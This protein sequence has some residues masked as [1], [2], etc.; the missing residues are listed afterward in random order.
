[1]AQGFLSLLSFA[2]DPDPTSIILNLPACLL[3]FPVREGAI[4]REEA[5]LNQAKAQTE[6]QATSLAERDGER[7]ELKESNKLN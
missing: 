1:M 5:M 4:A 6:A 3:L 7:K 2:F